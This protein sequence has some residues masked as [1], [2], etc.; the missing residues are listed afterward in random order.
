MTACKETVEI[1][2]RAAV[3]DVTPDDT[4][5]DGA[6]VEEVAAEA[7]EAPAE[8]A[9]AEAP[10]EEAVAEAPAAEAA[11]DPALVAEGEDVFRRCASCHQVGPEA[12]NR[13]GPILTGIV[14][15]PAGQVADFRY[16]TAFLDAAEG[17]LVWTP[18]TLAG[19]LADPKGYLPGNKMSFAGLRSDEEIAAVIAYLQS[20]G[21]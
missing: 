14:G 17:G 15:H 11:P 8:E 4:S 3:L 20:F 16:S 6:A 2:M 5:D 19:Y 12:E 9:V 7:T 21:G 18:E 1:T 13:T 10:A